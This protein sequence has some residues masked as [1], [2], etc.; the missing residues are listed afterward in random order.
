MAAADF[1]EHLRLVHFSVLITASTILLGGLD[2]ATEAAQS[3]L[4]SVARI[5]D[6]LTPRGQYW[7][8]ESGA[9]EDRVRQSM[10]AGYREPTVSYGFGLPGPQPFEMSL[11]NVTFSVPMGFVLHGTA[12]GYV[13][14]EWF[15]R[16]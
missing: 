16:S 1:L 2:R 5:T 15:R 8:A 10:F 12:P 14:L 6:A 9:L 4:A 7:K 11:P 3:D 13:P